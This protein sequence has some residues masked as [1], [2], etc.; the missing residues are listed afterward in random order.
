MIKSRAERAKDRWHARTRCIRVSAEVEQKLDAVVLLVSCKHAKRRPFVFHRVRIKT[1]VKE[2][3][4]T[5]ERIVSRKS[6]LAY[7]KQNVL[8]KNTSA[9][10][11]PAL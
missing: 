9:Y 1:I 5:F 8:F 6:V 11:K 10:W 2:D 3:L 7:H 4:E